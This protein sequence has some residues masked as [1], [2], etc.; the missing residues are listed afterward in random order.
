M[1]GVRAAQLANRLCELGYLLLDQ[2][3]V[4]KVSVLS[5]EQ[6]CIQRLSSLVKVLA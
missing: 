5:N 2:G 3:L 6:V 1:Q 4:V